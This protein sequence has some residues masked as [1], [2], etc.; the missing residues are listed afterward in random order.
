MT[1]KVNT[2]KKEI[3]KYG[4]AG[5]PTTYKEIY[6]DLVDVYLASIKD[7]FDEFIKSNNPLSG[8]QTY[9]RTLT[10]NLPTMEGFAKFIGIPKVTIY[11]WRKKQPEFLFSLEKIIDEQKKRLLE[12]GLSGAYNSTIAKLILSSNHGMAE[13][14]MSTQVVVTA[15]DIKELDKILKQNNLI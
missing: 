5:H 10:V 15:E 11:S 14:I 6:C 9:E 1:K 3:I 4:K 12:N 7:E 8:A 13:K 2:K